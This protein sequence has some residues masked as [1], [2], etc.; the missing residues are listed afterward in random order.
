MSEV[1]KFA[2]AINFDTD[3]LLGDWIVCI[4]G[5][6]LQKYRQLQRSRLSIF[7]MHCFGGLISHTLGLP[8][9]SP[10]VNLYLKEKDYL[11]FLSN[12]HF[13]INKKLVFERISDD[14]TEIPNN[15]PIFSLGNISLR[16][17][18]YTEKKE[19]IQK[20]TARKQRINWYNI[21]AVMNTENPDVAEEFDNLPY[22]KKIC[23]VP[24]KSN[25]DSAFYINPKVIKGN[26]VIALSNVVPMFYDIFDMLLY[27]KK[28]PLIEM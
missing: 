18:H 6:T 8:F 7:S 21:L 13:F 16:F 9:L 24:F 1:T 28:T 4:P 22:G 20:W 12:P 26:V 10:F 17:Q 15:Y 2:R 19:C 27:G 3:K 5:F 14:L 23:F 25:L 11:R